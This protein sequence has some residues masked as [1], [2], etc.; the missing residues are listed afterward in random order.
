[1]ELDMEKTPLLS[2]AVHIDGF[3]H[4][5]WQGKILTEGEEMVFKSEREL[6]RAVERL[7]ARGSG[8]EE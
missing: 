1:M 4:H 6:I 2:C 8:E 3:E 5:T 7:L